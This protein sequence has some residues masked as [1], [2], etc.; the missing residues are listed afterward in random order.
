M[1]FVVGES[2]NPNSAA[3]E[4]HEESTKVFKRQLIPWL[5]PLSK[6]FQIA[7][8]AMSV[9]CALHEKVLIKL[10]NMLSDIANK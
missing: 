7:L 1:M 4:R 6:Y 5:E 9:V 3:P 10:N 2:P 8:V